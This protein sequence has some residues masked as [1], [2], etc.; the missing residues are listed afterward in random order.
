MIPPSPAPT[1]PELAPIPLGEAVG[2]ANDLRVTL[3]CEGGWNFVKLYDADDYDTYLLGEDE[4]I[5]LYEY[6][7]RVIS[8]RGLK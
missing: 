7:G 6:L 8:E 4:I 2:L 5:S 1:R 3:T